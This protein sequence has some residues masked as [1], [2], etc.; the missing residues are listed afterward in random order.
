MRTG[1]KVAGFAPFRALFGG[2]GNA[3][4][5]VEE[6]GLLLGGVTIPFK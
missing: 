3:L 6:G 5:G 2:L 4:A 1:G